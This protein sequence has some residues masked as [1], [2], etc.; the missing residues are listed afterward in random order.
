[1]IQE[2]SEKR[3]LARYQKYEGKITKLY[4]SGYTFLDGMYIEHRCSYWRARVFDGIDNP[5]GKCLHLIVRA[6]RGL[7]VKLPE[8][9]LKEVMK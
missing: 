4:A 6:A 8:E 3:K 1:M 2:L 7:D 9:I 5:Y